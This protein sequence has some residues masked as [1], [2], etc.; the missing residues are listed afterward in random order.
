M[1]TTPVDHSEHIVLLQRTLR[2]VEKDQKHWNQKHWVSGDYD[3]AN[4][5]LTP[6]CGTS[7][8]F[9]GWAAHLDPQV[10]FADSGLVKII[11]D[12]EQETKSIPEWAQERL[13][14]TEEERFALFAA[15]ADL[16]G[17]REGVTRVID[18]M[19]AEMFP[20]PAPPKRPFE[21]VYERTTTRERTVMA[22]SQEEAEAVVAETMQQMNYP[23]IKAEW[24][25]R[26]ITDTTATGPGT[27]RVTLRWE[28]RQEHLT[29]LHWTV[30]ADSKEDALLQARGDD[31]PEPG[32]ASN[33]RVWVIE[34]IDEPQNWVVTVTYDTAHHEPKTWVVPAESEAAA[35]ARV[36][37]TGYYAETDGAYGR[38]WDIR[39]LGTGEDVS[40]ATTFS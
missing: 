32:D 5:E 8:C 31:F 37:R 14:L 20:P 6:T 36:R 9:A 11:D 39:A 26:S 19:L 12:L 4:G 24:S 15:G 18:R 17:L 23:G 38:K 28:G 10:K 33:S 16:E 1:T 13:G 3:L 34:K 27:Y 30:T 29:P 40:G 7:F 22:S 35:L 21:V 2:A 25:V